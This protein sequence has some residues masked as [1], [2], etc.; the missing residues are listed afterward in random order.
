VRRLPCT[1]ICSR[2]AQVDNNIPPV[3]VF[4]HDSHC[5]APQDSGWC[6]CPAPSRAASSASGKGG[7]AQEH[8]NLPQT[9]DHPCAATTLS[10]QATERMESGKSAAVA[11]AGGLIGILPTTLTSNAPPLETLLTICTSLITCVLFGVVYRYIIAS[12]PANPQLKG[13][14]VAAFGLTRG[15]VLAQGTIMSAEQVDGEVLAAAGLLAG[16]SMFLMAFAAA[17]VELALT[18]AVVQR[19]DAAPATGIESRADRDAR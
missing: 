3:T 4:L 11:S 9:H 13:G 15:L 12:D 2:C 8:R 6:C 18:A 10:I 19:L 16:Q 17:A 7:A 5:A 1:L 14:A